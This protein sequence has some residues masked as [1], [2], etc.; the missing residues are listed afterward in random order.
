MDILIVV[1]LI[2]GLC[3]GVDK[4]FQKLFRSQAKHHSGTAV[5]L[6][7][8]YATIGLLLTVLGVAAIFA[9]ELVLM[10]GGGVLV[11]TGL[12]L[13][14][15]YLSF[16]IYYDKQGFLYARFGRRSV[17]YS[18]KEIKAQLLYNSAGKILIELHMENGKAVAL[19]S[20]M[21]GVFTFMDTA[22]A[23]WLEQTGK[24]QEDCDFHDPDNSCWFPSL[25]V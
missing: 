3:F 16:G 14:T 5:R 12:G 22:F 1:V 7:K 6:N 18:Y 24:Q 13:I 20:T 10:V 19:P 2:F 15:Y 17:T 21:T 9:G 25:E 4:L 11:V 8:R 23:G